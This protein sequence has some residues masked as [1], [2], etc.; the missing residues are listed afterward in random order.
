MRPPESI[1]TTDIRA[2]DATYTIVVNDE[3]LRTPKGHLV[4]VLSWELANAM[5]DE[6]MA[7]G[8]VDLQQVTLYSLYAT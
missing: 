5:A 8:R 1:E 6:L 2:S 3:P 7:E 4:T